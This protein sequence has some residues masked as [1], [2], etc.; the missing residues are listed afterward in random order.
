MPGDRYPKWKNSSLFLSALVGQRLIR[1][2]IA[3]DTVAKQEVIFDQLGR[4]RDI[5]QGP[6]G[7]FYILTQAPTGAGTGMPLSAAT[8]GMLIRLIPQ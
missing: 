6:D 3:G 8:S 7:Y 1:L 2:E 5:V 4:V